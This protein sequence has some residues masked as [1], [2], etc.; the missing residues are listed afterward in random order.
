MKIN[1]CQ[2]FKS[3]TDGILKMVVKIYNSNIIPRKGD[4]IEDEAWKK[5]KKVMEVT[6]NYNIEECYVDLPFEE[7]EY[8]VEEYTK[9]YKSHG[10]KEIQEIS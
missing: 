7:T 10:W 1:I 5:P 2:R 6:I 8:S 3:T 4:F 9:M